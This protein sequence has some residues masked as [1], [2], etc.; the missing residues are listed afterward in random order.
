MVINDN[1]RF[2]FVHVPKAAGTSISEMLRSHRGNNRRW[3]ARQTKHE[4]LS[5]LERRWKRRAPWDLLLRR[6]PRG[7]FRFAFVR[8]PW[9]RLSSFYCYLQEKRP[10]REIAG[11]RS[12]R[13][14]LD[15][16]DSGEPWI[17]GL[18]SMRPQVDFLVNRR[19][20]LAMDYLGH[21]EHLRED[22]AEVC[23]LLGFSP[24]LPHRNRSS[25]S[26]RDYRAD[27]DDELVQRVAK[28][29]AVDIELFGY[30]FDTPLPTRRFS[31][32]L[33]GSVAEFRRAD[34]ST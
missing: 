22:L 29:F 3:L 9:D 2:I 14:F 32:P 12:F 4:T 10:R 23:G 20:E 6:S 27:Y 7:Y 26:D 13:H 21:F 19:G 30:R 11:V 25:H 8:N 1:Y 34:T 28:R 24:D 33:R 5:E 18:H 17:N 16:A 15:L 31:G